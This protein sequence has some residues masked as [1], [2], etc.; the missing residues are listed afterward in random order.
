MSPILDFARLSDAR[1]LA[2]AAFYANGSFF[3]MRDSQSGGA[4]PN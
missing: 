1:T 4:A 2:N 3:G